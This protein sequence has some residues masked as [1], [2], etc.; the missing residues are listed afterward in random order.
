[1]FSRSSGSFG[2]PDHKRL[3]QSNVD[4]LT[5]FRGTQLMYGT[6]PLVTCTHAHTAANGFLYREAGKAPRK[7]GSHL[8]G[9]NC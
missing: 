4:S 7:C 9:I 8:R 6:S 5:L 1:M 2:N 3:A